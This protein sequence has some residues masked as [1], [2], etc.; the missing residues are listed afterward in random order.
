MENWIGI[1]VWIVLGALIGLGM[2][3][4]LR[5]PENEQSGHVIILAILGA[6]RAVVGGML[7]VGIFHFFEPLALSP[8]GMAGS[9]ALSSL[10]TWTYRF[11]SRA[12]I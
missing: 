12:L 5:G 9:V 10:L 8:G 7:G 3:V 2:K 4:A 6:F 11:G 1:G